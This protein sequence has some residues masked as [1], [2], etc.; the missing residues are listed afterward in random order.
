MIQFTQDL[1]RYI[2]DDTSKEDNIYADDR[3][4]FFLL[5]NLLYFFKY[6]TLQKT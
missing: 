3:G 6:P 2:R 5:Y 1:C 4:I